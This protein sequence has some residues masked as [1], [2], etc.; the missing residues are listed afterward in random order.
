[1]ANFPVR[2][3]GGAGIIADIHPYDLPPNVFSAG[4]NVR[5][6]NGTVSRGPVA[7]E[8][9]D[10]STYDAAFTPSHLLSVPAF[11]A[12]N[13]AIVAVNN[14]FSKVVSIIG[15]TVS[16]VTP[17]IV[18]AADTLDP[19]THTFLGNVTYLNRRTNVPFQQSAADATFIPLT[20][21][22]AGWR[23]TV[24]R[25][26][27]D[28][29]VA[30][31]VKKASNEYPQMV[32]WS[33]LAQYGSAPQDWDEAST[34][35]SAGE[36]ILNQ[37]NG[38]IV[39][40]HV[41]RDTFMVYGENEVWAMTYTGGPFIFDFRKRFDDVGVINVNCVVEV[42]GRHYVFDRNDIIV[43]DGASKQ[44]IVHGKNKNF[45]FG[46]LQRDLQNLCFVTH[47]AKLNE[48]MFCYPSQDRLTGFRN[49]VT[50]CNRAAVYNYRRDSWTFYDLP[51]VSSAI[52]ATIATGLTYD[53]AS[54]ATP[55]KQFGGIYA[56]EGNQSEKHQ[57][58]G[59]IKSV[60]QGVT[61]SRVTGY[62]L[63]TGGRLN[64]PIITELLKDAFAERVGI[65][66]DE[67]G[68][69]IRS[70]KSLLKI[71]PQIAT[72]NGSGGVTF[73]FG[74]NDVSGVSPTWDTPQSFDPSTDYQLSVRK[75]GRYLAH[76][77]SH[78]GLT[79]FS[80]SGFD[81][82]MTVRGKR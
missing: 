14:D 20:A 52:Y 79:D 70:Y 81:A 25:A 68:V 17:P 74:A 80:Y 18:F 16:D 65:D 7:R 38:A 78:T 46:G 56:G 53:S 62:D 5:F 60:A 22:D 54:A 35:N 59:S 4:V 23:C 37:M 33:D 19:Y 71:Y 69:E 51:N 34:T 82:Q 42:D 3:L 55:Y 64:T 45:I 50:G 72:T 47:N 29:L 31:N 15:D 32:K 26:Y 73:Q 30:L 49:P 63:I 6:E 48:I 67:M 28:F 66:L 13:E 75:A 57:M 11:A 24:M 8:V 61:V 76:R 39:D 44:S 77:L 10:L 12:G 41:L 36:N 43:H 40:G 27:K 2:N 1:L 58:F 9:F 21:W